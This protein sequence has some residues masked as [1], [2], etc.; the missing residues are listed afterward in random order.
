MVVSSDALNTQ[1]PYYLTCQQKEGLLKAL[2]DFQAKKPIEYCIQQYPEDMLQGDGWSGLTV[3]RLDN[4]E[5]QPIKGIVL[6]NTCDIAPENQRNLPTKIVFAP[7]IS[8]K[9]Y[10]SLLKSAGLKQEQVDSKFKAIKEQKV[11][12]IFYLPVCGILEE[13]Y[14]ALLDDIHT[15]PKSLLSKERGVKKLFTLSMVGFYLFLFKISVHFCR[16]YE[17]VDRSTLSANEFT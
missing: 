7:L 10:G 9:K 15:I 11:S 2:A 17:E 12:S 13:E 14:I 3:V 4:Y 6:S 5:P 8:L 1:I 16:F